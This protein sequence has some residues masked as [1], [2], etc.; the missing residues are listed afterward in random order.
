MMVG[1]AAMASAE[2]TASAV[3]AQKQTSLQKN[4]KVMTGLVDLIL[5]DLVQD[6]MNAGSDAHFYKKGEG[7]LSNGRERLILACLKEPGSKQDVRIE[8]EAAAGANDH[9]YYECNQGKLEAGVWIGSYA[10]FA[11]VDAT[12]QNGKAET[13][14]VYRPNAPRKASTTEQLKAAGAVVSKEEL[15]EAFRTA[16]PMYFGYTVTD[17]AEYAMNTRLR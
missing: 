9:L 2:I 5:M 1:T 4:D 11:L 8:R 7:D 3:P 17:N 16:I 15:V 14:L 13:V 12:G 6:N 10:K